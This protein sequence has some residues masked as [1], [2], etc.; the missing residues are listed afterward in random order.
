MFGIIAKRIITFATENGYIDQSNQKAGIPGIPGCVEHA[1]SI[2]EE[3]QTARKEKKDLSVIW[4][5]LA[6]AYGSVP[7][8]LIDQA[9]EFFWIPEQV[10]A[11]V[12]LYYDK[13]KMRFTTGKFTME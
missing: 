6:N 5:D 11:M 2:W 10:R 9:M 13:F 7:H 1:F 8:V 12:R 3:I 4:L